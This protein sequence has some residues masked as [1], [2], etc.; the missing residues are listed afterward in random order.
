MTGCDDG[1]PEL[2]E[3]EVEVTLDGQSIEGASVLFAPAAGGWPACGT[4]NADS[5]FQLM[6]F[7]A[8]DGVILGSH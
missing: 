8:G 4:T 5:E 6:T 3:V 7:E 1:R 2:L